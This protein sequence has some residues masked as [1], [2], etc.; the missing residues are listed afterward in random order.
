MDSR[1]QNKVNK[2]LLKELS[3]YFQKNSHYSQGGLLTITEVKVTSDLSIA[4]VYISFMSVKNTEAAT[5]YVIDHA[6]SIR[7]ELGNALRNQLRKIPEF[8]FFL[9]ESAEYAQ[10][11]NKIMEN[12]N[13][14]PEENTK[15]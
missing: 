1:R 8:Q 13:I 6:N 14:P 10:N 3:E 9:D 12:L 11:I 4:R 5:D 7:G 15:E 2:L